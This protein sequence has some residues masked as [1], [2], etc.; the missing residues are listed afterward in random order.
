MSFSGDPR[1]RHPNYARCESDFERSEF[2]E[3]QAEYRAERLRDDEMLDGKTG[4]D[5]DKFLDGK[6]EE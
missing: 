6:I 5:I 1:L 4:S 2:L 3:R